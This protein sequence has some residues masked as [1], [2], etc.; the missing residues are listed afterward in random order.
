MVPDHFGSRGW[1]HGRQFFHRL[2]VKG[3]AWGWFMNIVSIVHF[4]SNLMPWLIWQEVPVHDPEAGDSWYIKEVYLF[5][6]LSHKKNGIMPH[7]ATRMELQTAKLSEVSQTERQ[8]SYDITYVWNLKKWYKWVYL[9]NRVTDV[10][11]KLTVARGEERDRLGLRY[12]HY[13]I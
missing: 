4:I 6:L 1:F 3:V 7:E 13:Y 11:S 9:Q 2:R 12:K 8:I 5:F 10:E